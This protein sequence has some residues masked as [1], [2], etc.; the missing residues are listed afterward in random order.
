MPQLLC[1]RQGDLTSPF[2]NITQGRRLQFRRTH[3]FNRRIISGQQAR[4]LLY[5]TSLSGNY[6]ISYL[7]MRLFSWTF[8]T[9]S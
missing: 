8:R 3:E 7:V 5:C 6:P 9:F 1:L 2:G 4:R